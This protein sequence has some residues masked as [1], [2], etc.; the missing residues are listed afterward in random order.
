MFS[1][2]GFENI[3]DNGPALLVFYHGAIPL[4]HYYLIV[5]CLLYKKRL[6]NAVGDNFLFM[7]P[8]WRRLM[9]ELKVLPGPAQ[10]CVKILKKGNILSISPGGVRE[11][12]F[13]DENYKLIWK[14]R[15]GFAKVA[16]EAKVPIIPMF[17]MNIREAFVSM[18]V[19]RGCLKRIYE[20]TKLPVVPVYGGFPVKLKTII[21]NPIP[22]DPTVTPEQLAKRTHDEID[23]LIKQH[24]RLPGSI[25]HALLD[26]LH[27]CNHKTC[28]R[29]D[30]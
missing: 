14:N 29:K 17:T 21:G 13:G 24:Q 16:I 10:E 11:A 27:K 2:A 23:K 12:Q 4:D 28:K 20:K 18:K 30:E 9:K 15:I 22:Y 3:P 6:I 8:G 19:G 1:I 5:K 26:R 7:I 25:T